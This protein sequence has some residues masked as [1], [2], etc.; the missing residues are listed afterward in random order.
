MDA[1]VEI[2]AA[3]QLQPDLAEA[4]KLL[5]LIYKQQGDLERGIKA[6]AYYLTLLPTAG[7]QAE[8]QAEIKQMQNQ[9]ASKQYGEIPAGKALFVFI[10][11]TGDQ[12][13]V[14]VGPYFIEVPPKPV[15]QDIFFIAKV[16]DPGSYTW[17]AIAPGGGK[18]AEDASGHRAFDFTVAA[19]ETK[20]ACVGS[21]SRDVESA[22][23]IHS[24]GFWANRQDTSYTSV[25]ICN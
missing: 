3:L 9:L 19:G 11:Y 8:I 21:G 22:K 17:T 23:L 20:I 2:Q 7:D 6:L 25:G 12:W 15:D 10:N 14:D 1:L 16:I 4:Y 24:G 5:G 13:N 18:R